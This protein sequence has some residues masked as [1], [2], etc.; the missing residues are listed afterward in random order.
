MYGQSTY[1]HL[2]LDTLAERGLLRQEGKKSVTKI[3][4]QIC[5]IS[6]NGKIPAGSVTVNPTEKIVNDK[7][8]PLEKCPD[9]NAEVV[10]TQDF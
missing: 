4:L 8:A 6:V 1:L 9:K 5:M 3:S 10:F 7:I 2:D